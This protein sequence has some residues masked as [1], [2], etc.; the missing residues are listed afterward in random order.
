MV[1]NPELTISWLNRFYQW[2]LHWAH[3]NYAATVLFIWAFAESSFFPIPPDAFLIALV[4]AARKKAF[5]FATLCSI[6]SVFGG[7]FGYSI[8]Y[9]LWWNGMD[10][11]SNLA[12]FFFTH[13][14][15]FNVA[16]F[17]RVQALYEQWN[18]WVVFTAGFTPIPYKLITISAGAFKIN[19]TVFIIASAIGRA[20][21]FYIVSWLLWLYGESIKK[22]IEKYLGWLSIAFV[23]LLLGGF[24][25]IKYWL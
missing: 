16:Q 11:Y 9:W 24:V 15:G 3:T 10:V 22:F 25:V 2:L 12:N 14:P 23:V 5:R 17:I 4:I 21:R 19:F 18:F 6:A 13:I 20:A 8:G 1:E 7:V